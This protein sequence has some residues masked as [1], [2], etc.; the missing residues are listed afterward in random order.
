MVASLH[1][2]ACLPAPRACLPCQPRRPL[3]LACCMAA[4]VVALHSLCVEHHCDCPAGNSF[5]V[6][7]RQFHRSPGREVGLGGA[8]RHVAPV[9]HVQAAI[10]STAPC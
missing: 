10:L 6:S 1:D 9:S 7:P 8:G 4:E 2:M 5:L 3:A